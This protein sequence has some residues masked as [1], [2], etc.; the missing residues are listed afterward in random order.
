MKYS[1]I[2]FLTLIMI[3]ASIVFVNMVNATLEEK[4]YKF[5]MISSDLS[6]DKIVPQYELNNRGQIT[7]YVKLN[8]SFLGQNSVLKTYY[9]SPESDL[10]NYLNYNS[11]IVVNGNGSSQTYY[12]SATFDLLTNNF[13]TGLYRFYRDYE[14][15]PLFIGY[16]NISGSLPNAVLQGT[17]KEKADWGIIASIKEFLNYLFADKAEITPYL[18]V[19]SVEWSRSGE[20][21][22]IYANYTDQN[23][24]PILNANCRLNTDKWGLLQ[25]KYIPEKKLY[26]AQHIADSVGQLKWTVVCGT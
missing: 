14:G 3:I 25:M 5:Q 22:I 8:A 11:M 9:L 26:E 4:V 13:T 2:I 16:V 21:W 18:E 24:K 12:E 1:L 23:L 17:E 15:I 10:G 7:V 6:E 19:K 20:N